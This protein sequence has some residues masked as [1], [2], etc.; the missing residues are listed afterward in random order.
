MDD[1]LHGQ[2]DNILTNANLYT[3]SHIS[4][5]LVFHSRDNNIIVIGRKDSK[6]YIYNIRIYEVKSKLKGNQKNVTNSTFCN[7]IV[8]YV[9]SN[10]DAHF[11]SF[12][13]WTWDNKKSPSIQMLVLNAVVYVV[14]FGLPLLA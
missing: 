5:F 1:K 8:L 7:L 3:T 6:I 14:C 4:T 2:C 12:E 10:V 13:A 11:F 9:S